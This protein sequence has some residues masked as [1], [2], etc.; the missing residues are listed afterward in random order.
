LQNA[1]A[2]VAEHDRGGGRSITA[3]KVPLLDRIFTTGDPERRE[4]ILDLGGPSQKLLDRLA[5][6]RRCRVE[7]ADLVANRGLE[8]LNDAELIDT[9]GAGAIRGLLPAP[10]AEALDLIFCWDLPN[11]LRLKSLRRLCDVLGERAAPGCRVHMLIAYSRRDMP[12]APAHFVL[13]GDGQVTQVC[14]DS[15]TTAA[16]RYS[17]ENLGTALG[18]FR[19]E[20][21][22]LLANG[23][24]EFVYA[25]PR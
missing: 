8:T 4:V 19:Y 25:W 24:Q 2:A 10:N 17:P 21:G 3:F 18:N 1:A 15:R 11:Y 9:E 16:P 6:T 14:E 20:R 13:R 5:E 7:I 23:M 12:L 22:V